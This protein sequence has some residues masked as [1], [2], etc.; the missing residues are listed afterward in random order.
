MNWNES[1]T[2][3]T[4]STEEGQL[5]PSLIKLS[6]VTEIELLILKRMRDVTI[7]DH[8][9]N[10]H[11]SGFDF[12]GLRDWQPGDRPAAIDWAQS[13]INNFSPLDVRDFEQPSS[14]AVVSLRYRSES[15]FKGVIRPRI[16][17]W[18][19]ARRDCPILYDYCTHLDTC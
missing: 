11:G 15:S 3:Q 18:S 10:S 8:R 5:I 1:K 7:G 17:V 12:T 14:A 16:G 4:T 2:I 9:S 13:M 19:S 6:D